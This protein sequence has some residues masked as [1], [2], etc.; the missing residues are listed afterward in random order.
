[1]MDQYYNKTFSRDR[2]QWAK[3]VVNYLVDAFNPNILNLLV[4]LTEVFLFFK[5]F[6]AIFF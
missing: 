4:F 5:H 2:F 3:C 1:M 6:S